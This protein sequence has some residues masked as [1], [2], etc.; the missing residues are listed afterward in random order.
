LK[1]IVFATFGSLGD[2]HPYV[3]LALELKR[4]GHRPL[5]ATSDIQRGAVESAGIEFAAMRPGAEQMGDPAQL[6]R[7]L[8]H[9]TKG[10]EYLIRDL[11]MPQVRGA[12][13][14]LDRA[15]AGAEM[16]FIVRISFAV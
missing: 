3:A 7:K 12:Y 9:P 6:V 15:G 11:V 10:P 13:E 2:V 4:R 16:L 8:F 1:R 5:I 14:D